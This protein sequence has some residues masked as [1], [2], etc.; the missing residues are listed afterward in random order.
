MAYSQADKTIA[1]A[2]IYQAAQL[3]KDIAWQ[4]KT[5][6]TAMES[7]FESLLNFDAPDVISVYGNLS[8]IIQGL[9]TLHNQLDSQSQN[10]NT[11]IMRY[12]ITLIHLQRKL[13]KNPQLLQKVSS[14]LD[15]VKS[16]LD[17][18]D[19]SHKNTIAK[20]ADIYK[21]TIST[22]QPKIIVEGEQVYL[23]NNDNADKIRALLLAGI[24]AAVLWRQTG[25]SRLQL[26]FSRKK[27]VKTAIELSKKI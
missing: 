24:R 26:I 14:R 21:S 7:S 5:N 3:V 27:Y 17:Y 15:T 4:G 8:G 18:F 25:G 23:S 6:S 2:G 1:L 11:D 20:L 16:Q 22:I 19:L 9:R 10:R 13:E 12:V